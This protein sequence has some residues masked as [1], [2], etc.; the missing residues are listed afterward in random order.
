[1]DVRRIDCGSD[2]CLGVG[3]H[4]PGKLLADVPVADIRNISAQ[5]LHIIGRNEVGG[6]AVT[7]NV[8]ERGSVSHALETDVNISFGTEFTRR[9]VMI[10]RPVGASDAPVT[11]RL[12]LLNGHFFAK[13][14]Y[15]DQ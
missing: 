2:S 13:A 9:L 1:M 6:V 8:K 3:W 4:G 10:Y 5:N 14:L 12:T 15:A 7:E 11:K